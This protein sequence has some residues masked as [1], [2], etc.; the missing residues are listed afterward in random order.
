MKAKDRDEF[1]GSWTEHVNQLGLLT[2]S[3]PEEHMPELQRIRERLLEMVK[4]ATDYTY[5]DAKGLVP[6]AKK[7]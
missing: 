5:A 7:A 3:L 6:E 4:I 2:P 1:A